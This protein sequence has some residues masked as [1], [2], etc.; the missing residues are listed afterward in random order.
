M[1]H[2]TRDNLLVKVI[3]KENKIGSILLTTEPE[4]NFLDAV[5][6]SAGPGKPNEK[7]GYEPMDIKAGDK[8]CFAKYQGQKIVIDQ[9][10][11]LLVNA[12]DI[13]G[14]YYD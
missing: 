10:E 6:K 2:P 4:T 1:F 14:V 5:V 13:C 12:K 9:E 7:G 11:F 8:V 3:E